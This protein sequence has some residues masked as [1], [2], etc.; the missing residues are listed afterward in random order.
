[1]KIIYAVVSHWRSKE[2]ILIRQLLRRQ[3]YALFFIEP[4]Q[5][6]NRA[7]IPLI[8]LVHELYPTPSRFRAQV[9]SVSR[10]T[11]ST[12]YFAYFIQGIYNFLL[13]SE[14]ERFPPFVV[15]LFSAELR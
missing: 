2:F 10:A 5:F 11:S 8:F 15:F 4:A 14:T 12:N 1:M 13:F 7:F 6:R 3:I 9:W